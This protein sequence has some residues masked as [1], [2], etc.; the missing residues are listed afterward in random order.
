VGGRIGPSGASLPLRVAGGLHALVLS[1]RDAGLLAA[2][3]PRHADDDAL[4]GAVLEALRRH[5]GF[6]CRWAEGAPQTNEVRRSAVLIA[7]AHWLDER[8]GLP[9]QV[10]EL[11][12][13]AGLNLLF[14]RYALELDGEGWGPAEPALRLCPEWR[15]ERPPRAAPR[16]AERRGVDLN[17]L[18]LGDPED[19]LRLLSFVWPDQPER[20]ALVRRAMAAGIAPVDR[21]DA[22]DWLEGRLARPRPGGAHLICHTVAWQYF[23]AD[24]QARG[25]RIIE[26]AG[27][28]ATD[29]APLAWFGMEAD[30]VP[31]S[32]ALTLRLWPG[33]HRLSMG[34]AD[35]HGRW[36]E[37]DAG[38]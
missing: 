25:R 34:R 38:P 15:G 6:L 16:I 3:P 28:A 21:G 14:D 33:D 37:W 11:G 27:A 5:D 12:A 1:G 35:F 36:V 7:A 32:A 20:M 19:R 30:E 29:G 10:S 23:P 26:A 18:R 13:S 9:L 17:P 4:T 22:V 8:F 31:G 24:R 2:Y